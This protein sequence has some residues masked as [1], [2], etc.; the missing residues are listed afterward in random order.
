[1]KT[2]EVRFTRDVG[3]SVAVGR[4]ADDNGRIYFEY[5]PE[6]LKL[7]LNLSPFRLPFEDG[8]FEHTD[9]KFGPLPGLVDDS[10]PDGW[11]LL[12]M[13]RHF[14]NLRMDLAG[15]SPLHR[16]LWLGTRTMGALTYHPPIDR[17]N[18]DPHAFD[19]HDL[20]LR[21]QK[22]LSGSSHEIL[23]Q[24]LLAGG[25]PGGARP[26]VLVGVR[27]KDLISGADD[28]PEG[29][30]H[31]MVKFFAKEDPED[32]GAVEYA[33]SLMAGAAGIDMPPTRLFETSEGGRFFGARR[34]D[35]DGNRRCHLHTFGGLIQANFRVPSNDYADLLKVTLLLTRN[36]KDVA[37]MFRRMVFNVF[38]HNRDDHVK[39]FSYI[40]DDTT[41]EWTISPAYDLMYALGPGGE[42][43]MTVAG[44][45]KNPGIAHMLELAKRAGIPQKDAKAIIEEVRSA[46]S[47]RSKFAARAGVGSKGK[48]LFFGKYECDSPHRKTQTL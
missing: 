43:T 48:K 44:E 27:G 26:K 42:H 7:G 37:Q 28:L 20:A 32:I 35:R 17:K 4:L 24:L 9:K 46:I 16:L 1:M 12:L 8:L 18:V 33:Y 13:D 21:S 19:L 41:G 34:F 2:A 39:N 5:S 15:I 38:A 30:E 36:Q 14:Q 31:W 47:Q 10:L 3:K 45:G 23:P 40:M 29:F 22:I 11:G 25:S 6:T